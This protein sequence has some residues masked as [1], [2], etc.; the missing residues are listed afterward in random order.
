M[1]IDAFCFCRELELL[2][3]RAELMKNDDVVHVL[4][5]SPYTFSGK[6]KRLYFKEN[7]KEFR[8]YKIINFVADVPNN[9]DTWAN[10]KAQRN[11]ITQAIASLGYLYNI[12]DETKVIISDVDEVVDI[13]K[14]L[15]WNGELAALDMK[16]FG[17]YLNLYECQWTR[18][19]ICN[20]KYLKEHSPEEVRN[21]GFPETIANAGHHW[22]YLG[23]VDDILKKFAAFSHQEAE[24]QRHATRENIE[25]KLRT[26]E[27]L[28]GNDLWKII[29]PSELPALLRHPEFEH[30]MFKK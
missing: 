13:S 29:D 2:K 1:I 5:E 11:Y 18:A 30:L 14:I 28:W 10:E 9:G 16:K 7:E 25:H 15:N 21:S 26:G 27:S 3:I 22:S 4:V 6:E 24:V 12:T 19:K 20:W 8:D 17:F 23:D